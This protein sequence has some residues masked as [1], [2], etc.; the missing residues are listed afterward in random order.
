MQDI[1]YEAVKDTD[2]KIYAQVQK[3]YNSKLHFHR[4]FEIA[5]ITEGEALYKVEEESFIANTDDIIFSH[6]YYR[7]C[8]FDT[9]Y[10]SKIVIAVPNALSYDFSVLFKDTTLPAHLS[11]TNFNK[12][13]LP[14]FQA[15]VDADDN[16]SEIILKGYLN[17][18]FGYLAS[19]YKNVAISPKSKN[20]SIIVEILDFINLHCNEPLTLDILSSRFGY[21]KSYF[22][23]L[24]N[25]TVGISLNDYLNIAR[26]NRFEELLQSNTS[27][28]LTDIIYKAGFQS[29]STFYRVKAIRKRQRSLR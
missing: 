16:T 7:H 6:C 20:V 23:R 17:L 3:P 5:Y 18:I 9:P 13:L 19:H 4:A 15:L 10:H 1:F 27:D 24:F 21:N 2:S 25:K 11:D 14:Y 8:S 29:P 12:K 26:L 28:S 22:S